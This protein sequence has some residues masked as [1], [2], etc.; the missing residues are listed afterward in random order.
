MRANASGRPGSVEA[1]AQM[2]MRDGDDGGALL[3]YEADANVTGPLAGVGQRLIGGA[4]QAHDARV[5]RGRS[6]ARSSRRA[7]RGAGERPPRRTGERRSFAPAPATARGA[8]PRRD[9]PQRAGRLPAGADRRR[10][11]P[12]D[13]PPLTAAGPRGRLP[14]GDTDE[15]VRAMGSAIGRIWKLHGD[16]RTV[17]PGRW[18][19]RTSGCT[20]R[21]CSASARQHVLAMF[22]ATAL[23]PVLTGFPVTTTLLLLGHRHDPVQ[24]A[25]AQPRA[26]LHRLELRVHRAGDRREGA[27]R[28]AGG[29]R[30]HPLSP[31]SRCS[32]IGLIVDRVGYRVIEFLLP[33]VVTGAIVALIGLNLAPV[34][35]D[36]FTAAG[37]HRAGHARARSCSSASRVQGLPVAAV[38][39]PRG[40]GRLR[41]RRDPRQGQL[42]RAC[43]TADWVGFP[44]FTTPTF[45]GKAIL[46]IVPAVI[47]VLLAEN[48][49]HVKAVAT[50]TERD[51]DP[52]IGRSFMGDGVATTISRP[53]RRLGHDDLRREH[54][55]HG[56][57]A[58]LL[59]ARVPDRR[60]GRDPARP[61]AEVRRDHQR[62]PDRRARRRGDRAVRHDR[63]ARRADL[64]RGAAW[65]SATRST[66]SPPRSR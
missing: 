64:D 24:P 37:G 63:R 33:P 40:G 51:L 39:V 25:H 18:C 6:T 2:R 20:C 10:R 13:R 5:P 11:R 60:R 65:T 41:V 46:L 35:K 29:A 62:D 61:A 27:R 19:A 38:G 8:D 66:S 50:M 56:L 28:R 49:G 48:A 4:A 59:D 16:G 14:V 30:R 7:R 17:G 55:R 57:H 53:V 42:G 12:L 1:V 54:R 22:G 31:A 45:N 23:V 36:Q 34:A 47:L 15:G 9:R 58:R 44:D 52:L 21:T 43:T 32:S 3:T 26:V